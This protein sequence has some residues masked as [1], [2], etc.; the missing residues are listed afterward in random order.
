MARCSSIAGPAPSVRQATQDWLADRG[1][2][3]RRRRIKAISKWSSGRWSRVSEAAGS[4]RVE[5]ASIKVLYGQDAHAPL[6][7]PLHARSESVRKVE[8][9]FGEGE[10]SSFVG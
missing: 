8:P 5:P 2:D 3:S 6:P 10:Q 4:I 7:M 1:S 9:S